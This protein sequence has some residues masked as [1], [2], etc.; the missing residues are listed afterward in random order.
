VSGVAAVRQRS[1]RGVLLAQLGTID[2]VFAGARG[3]PFPI[4]E[5]SQHRALEICHELASRPEFLG[6]SLVGFQRTAARADLKVEVA[7]ENE[8]LGHA[9]P[10][11][12]AKQAQLS[13]GVERQADPLVVQAVLVEPQRLVGVAVLDHEAADSAKPFPPE[14]VAVGVDAHRV[15]RAF[16]SFF[17]EPLDEPGFLIRDLQAFFL[18][19]HR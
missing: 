19:R 16:D 18:T 6:H 12:F 9:D 17:V 7:G 1:P 3:V 13:N 10:G 11:R 14:R 8:R 4:I 5:Q 15:V 2:P